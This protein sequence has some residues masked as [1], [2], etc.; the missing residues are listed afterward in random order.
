MSQARRILAALLSFL[1]AA[2]ASAEWILPEP[3]SEVYDRYAI[4]AGIDL[5]VEKESQI[6]GNLHSNGAVELKKDTVVVGDVSAV[7]T[8]HQEGTVSGTVTQGATAVELPPLL[9][10][11]QA[12]DLADRIYLEDTTFTNEV[13]DDVVYVDG[14]V[15]IVGS[16]NGVGA[17][18]SSRKMRL[19]DLDAGSGPDPE[20]L[21]SL[22]SFE[23]VE[24]GR[25]RSLRGLVRSGRDVSLGE[26]SRFEGVV[27]ADRKVRLAK[28][29]TLDF[30]EPDTEPPSLRLETP[31]PGQLTNGATLRFAGE[32]EDD[33][34]L[35]GVE[36]NGTA[37]I[38]TDGRFDAQVSL[39]EG[40]ST[41]IV[42]ALDLAGNTTELTVEVHRLT[43]PELV[44]TAPADLSLLTSDTV[45]VTGTTTPGAAVTINGVE[46]TVAGGVFIAE[47]LPL[48][49]GAN[50]FDVVASGPGDGLT[51]AKVTIFR[52]RTPPRLEVYAPADGEKVRQPTVVVHGLVNDISLGATTERASVTV[53]GQPAEVANRSFLSNPV[54]LEPGENVFPVV[55]VD[56]S[57]NVTETTVRVTFAPPT[58]PALRI[59]S[60]DLQRALIGTQLPEPLTV[61]L[62]DA[63]GPLAGRSVFFKVTGD[64]G[65]LTG[66]RR[67]L[68]VTTDAA[69]RASTTLTFGNHAGPG[70]Q[71]VRVTA[72]GVVGGVGFHA[73]A[74]PG[75][76]A[77]LF[78]DD[79]DQQTGLAGRSLPNPFVVVVTDAG[80]NRLEGV[81]VS[82]RVVEGLGILDGAAGDILVASDA[83]GKAQTTLTLDPT[84]GIANNVVEALLPNSPEARFATFVAS[85]RAAG[86]PSETVVS[87]LVID[88]TD[89]PVPGV[90]LHVVGTPLSTET[91][92]HG[93]FRIPEAPVGSLLLEV[94]GTTTT[95]PGVW[96]HLEFELTTL[97]GRDNTLGRPIY[98]L[99]LDIEG[100][101]FVSATEGGALALPELPGFA[102]EVEP[103]SVTFPDGGQS[104]V[105]SVTVV[106]N[107][108]VPMVPNFGQQPRLVFSIQPGGAIFDPPAHLT[109]PN[110]DGLEPGAVTELYSFDHHLGS[111]VGIGPGTVSEDGLRVVSNPGV[112]VIEAGW[113][114]GGNPTESG[115]PH[116]CPECQECDGSRCVS[117]CL[118]DTP[119]LG[120]A[121]ATC[122]CLEC[123]ETVEICAET[124]TLSDGMVTAETPTAALGDTIVFKA[125]GPSDSGGT[126]EIR[127]TDGTG[128]TFETLAGRAPIFEYVITKPSGDTVMGVGDMAQVA[129]EDCGQ[130][131]A[132]FTARVDR[133]CPPA[134][135]E[136]GEATVAV[137]HEIV[138]ETVAVVPEDRSRTTLGVFELVDLDIQPEA[139]LLWEL[140]GG[141]RLQRERGDANVLV[142]GGAA[143]ETRITVRSENGGLCGQLSFSVLQPTAQQI[144]L[145]EGSRK[146]INGTASCGFL[147]YVAVLPFEE[148]SFEEIEVQEQTALPSIAS[149]CFEEDFANELHP[150]GAWVRVTEGNL[151]NAT[152]KIFT[153]GLF[154]PFSSGEFLWEI[155]VSYR[156]VGSGSTEETF[157]T[158][159]HHS[160]VAEDGTM[161][162]SKG[163]ESLTCHPDD[164]TTIPF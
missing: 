138:S 158:N 104:G 41:A 49:N 134:E 109:L 85:G 103:G 147:G 157:A 37:V 11:A 31:S 38:S 8:V 16:L 159:Q 48:A 113:H 80:F 135:V 145:V 66:D 32:A 164:P 14:K 98:L 70:S 6:S 116:D 129:A 76:P 15:R 1:P 75:P 119:A 73:T 40:T 153:G 99:P 131:T 150:R 42:R 18:I 20:N 12:L 2:T 36:I 81:P 128:S 29:S 27:I 152:D 43:L 127:C 97:P 155:P 107:D 60:G 61:R 19:D 133:E 93:L 132:R 5:K 101:L 63:S 84:E 144:L 140:A 87:G 53:A 25:R 142:A 13:I 58:G 149:G 79:G 50:V 163:G 28:G 105:V 21:V 65:T 52:D 100:G 69:G 94:D 55:A 137:A 54:T 9:T 45:D 23:D 22:I 121:K 102:L 67:Q 71:R 114:C 124:G 111:F 10:E 123:P 77:H 117:I 72:P 96:P 51:T 17:L 74:L 110:V 120:F 139:D 88:N 162:T 46:T 91:D 156:Q 143:S 4:V 126:K 35:A 86:L 108:K 95:R 33:S 62:E 83:A 64:S 68:V 161:T 7:G 112:G 136:L 125:S 106:H 130:Y 89:Q 47:E 59:E 3:E 160:L 115:T 34:G 57:G 122:G 141:G 82:F 39:P 146:H 148:V 92:A 26:G 56:P 24:I 90:S 78:V 118:R 30:L 151:L 44:V 154:P